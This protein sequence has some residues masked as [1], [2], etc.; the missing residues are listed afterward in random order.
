MKILHY[1]NSSEKL[2]FFRK[3]SAL[4]I[5]QYENSSEKMCFFRKFFILIF[6]IY[7]I[8]LQS[9]STPY[10]VSTWNSSH[11]EEFFR[12]LYIG[13]WYGV[14]DPDTGYQILIQSISTWYKVSAWNSSF[15]GEFFKKWRNV[16][17]PFKPLPL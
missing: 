3:F 8:L 4:K 7:Q 9:I 5:L 13:T 17:P 12:K 16:N 15:S 2:R 1:E 10:R 11:S 14:S 6:L